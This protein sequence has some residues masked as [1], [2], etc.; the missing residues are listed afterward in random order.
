MDDLRRDVI[1]EHSQICIV[2]FDFYDLSI[3]NRC[4]NSSDILVTIP[5]LCQPH[6]LLKTVSVDWDYSMSY[7]LLHRS[8]WNAFCGPSNALRKPTISLEE[9]K[10]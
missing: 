3:Y 5:Q 9:E 2:D 6:P 8:Q 1:R 7:G 10:T 4:E